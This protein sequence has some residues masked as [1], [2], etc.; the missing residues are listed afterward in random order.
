MVHFP[1]SNIALAVQLNQNQTGNNSIDKIKCSITN[2]EKRILYL[3]D[4]TALFAF[5]SSL[6]CA[7]VTVSAT[8][9]RG[10]LLQYCYLSSTFV[11]V[12]HR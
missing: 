1:Q 9:A 12:K 7:S 8:K 11:N 5:R 2:S 6:P 10:F 4:Y 3:T